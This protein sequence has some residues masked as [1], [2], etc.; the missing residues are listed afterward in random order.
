V[1]KNETPIERC[2]RLIEASLQWGDA[3]GWSNEDFE[4]LS[5]KIY[6]VTG[7]RLSVSTLKRI[8]GK[9]RYDSSPTAATLNALARFAGFESWRDLASHP[10]GILTQLSQPSQPSQ[11]ART[12]RRRMRT[13]LVIVISAAIIGLLSLF[14][15]RFKQRPADKNV[16]MPAIVF[17]AQQTTDDL[18][19]SVVFNYDADSL[20]PGELMIQQSWDST[21]REQ[22]APNGRQHTSLYYYPG[23]FIACLIVDGQTRKKTDV[24]IRTKGWKGII[25]RDP[26]PIYLS[27]EEIKNHGSLVISAAS[28][29]QKTGSTLF[30]NTWA[31]FDNVRDFNDMSADNFT[32]STSL[33]NTAAVEQCL[34][35][36]V[37]ISILG[38]SGAFI[39]PLV[40]KGCISNINVLTGDAMI[41]GKDHDLSAFGCDFRQWQQLEGSVQDHRLKIRLNGTQ[42]FDIAQQRSIGKIIG[43][44]IAFE[45]PGEIRKMLLSSPA[46][47]FDLMADL[48][49]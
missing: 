42:I 29:Q 5:E 2:R 8:W 30:N 16:N 37:S 25:Q 20:H 3:A 39:I 32:F 7:V 48:T 18:P 11:P 31:E 22:I 10:Q 1:T 34:C 28:L 21:R 45:G 13:G 23:Y 12:G 19:N 15:S 17:T 40:D 46:G 36:R 41:H 14:G 4:Q 33:R 43:I 9:V 49:H 24:F 6:V 47:S 35:R 26:F 27:G 38:T 44:R